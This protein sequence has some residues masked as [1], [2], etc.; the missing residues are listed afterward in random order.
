MDEANEFICKKELR[1]MLKKYRSELTDKPERSRVIA[2]KV[3]PMLRGNIMAYIS[4]GSEVSTDYLIDSLLA[5]D[6]TVYAPYTHDGIIT[7]LKLKKRGVPDRF[8]NLPQ[9]CYE[10]SDISAKIDFCI[11][12]LLGF[13]EKGYRIGYGKGCYDRFFAGCDV[14][15]I[16]LAFDGQAIKFLPEPT[17]VPL[18]CCV[19][20][21]DVIYF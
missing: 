3:L 19:T 4:M 16:G 7:P 10:M 18:D 14:F 2:D 1:V 13:N 15:K 17:D 5:S 21:K 20:D 9:E 11:T 6:C 12:P 8:G